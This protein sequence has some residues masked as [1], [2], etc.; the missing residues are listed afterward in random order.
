M[1]RAV[2]VM[3]GGGLVEGVS[4][5]VANAADNWLAAW[6]GCGGAGV[7]V[8]DDWCSGCGGEDGGSA[9]ASSMS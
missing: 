1:F 9:E 6:V 2:V 5:R 7:A 3:A 8:W 4:L